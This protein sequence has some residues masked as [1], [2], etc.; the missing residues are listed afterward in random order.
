[1]D[2]KQEVEQV[3]TLLQS[4]VKYIGNNRRMTYASV[5]MLSIFTLMFTTDILGIPDELM[6]YVGNHLYQDTMGIAVI[7]I[8][9]SL[10]LSRTYKEKTT[11]DWHLTINKLFWVFLI[12]IFSLTNVRN[13]YLNNMH[14]KNILNQEIRYLKNEQ[15]GLK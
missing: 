4:I 6:K 12:G 14:E 3:Q 1:M 10:P 15:Q 13:A 11:E 8:F 9:L 2:K 5:L 7:I